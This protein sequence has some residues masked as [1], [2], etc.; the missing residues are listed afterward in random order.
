MTWTL[1]SALRD[2]AAL[3]SEWDALNTE[4]GGH[5]L[6]DSGFVL[7]LLKHFA[8]DGVLLGSH[9]KNGAIC[10]MI[11]L[12]PRGL[13]RWVSFQPSQ[14]PLGLLLSR[15]DAPESLEGYRS[16]IRDLPGCAIQF[17][18]LQQ[19][20]DYS[21]LRGI[22]PA[23]DFELLDYI[24]TARLRLEGT[25]EEYWRSRS[26][27]LRHN[28]ERQIRRLAEQQ[29]SL[30]LSVLSSP[31]RMAT[32]VS[33]HAR[34]ESQGWKAGTSTAIMATNAQ[35]AFYTEML[36][37][38][39][40]RGEA[41]IYQLQ[42]DGTTVASDLCLR[43]NRMLVVLKTAYDENLRGFSPALLMHRFILQALF[44]ERQVDVI[45][46]YGR[47]MDWHTKWTR[48][49]RTLFHL[50]LYRNR[51]VRRSVMVIKSSRKLASE[52]WRPRAAHELGHG[53]RAKEDLPPAG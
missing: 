53:S 11:L 38:F 20:P 14:A 39:A 21:C 19:D 25:Y 12:E 13:G 36:T 34:L 52:F 35:G 44:S 15:G 49:C 33:D 28:L 51:F 17:S 37:H 50:N 29:R 9:E 6:L 47:V 41:V 10:Q 4:R 24:E 16:L 48:D 23:D 2:D 31:D 1:K 46:F 45:E 27:N 7:P 8:R 26:G 32:G 22:L 40:H 18:A 43:R 30:T 42:L 3:S 5:I